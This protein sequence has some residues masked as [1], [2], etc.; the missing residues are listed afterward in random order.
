MPQAIKVVKPK[1]RAWRRCV[2]RQRPGARQESLR[3]ATEKTVSMSAAAVFLARKV[4][5]HLGAHAMHLPRPFPA[6]GGNDAQSTKL[7]TNQ[8]LIAF[9]VELG[10][11]QHAAEGSEGM[12]LLRPIRAGWRNR[13]TE[14]D[15]PT[16]PE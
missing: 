3:L 12:G 8:G 1:S 2:S 14:P 7:L 4:G 16:G 15:L 9:G 10:I 11:G 13:S 5:A 6:F